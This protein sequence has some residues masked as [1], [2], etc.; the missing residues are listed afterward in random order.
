MQPSATGAEMLHPR[1]VAALIQLLFVIQGASSDATRWEEVSRMFVR[2]SESFSG[3]GMAALRAVREWIGGDGAS[4]DDRAMETAFCRLPAPRMRG[5][6]VDALREIVAP[7]VTQ[8]VRHGAASAYS[9]ATEARLDLCLEHC[10]QGMMTFAADGHCLF[11]NRSAARLLKLPVEPQAH[12]VDRRILHRSVRKL[13][14]DFAA[15]PQRKGEWLMVRSIEVGGEQVQCFPL[16]VG[17]PGLHGPEPLLHLFLIA[18]TTSEDLAE[19]L[20]RRVHLSKQETFVVRAL[21]A[22]KS[23]SAIA[24]EMR[25]S[26][27]TVRTYVE[28]VYEKLQVRNRYELL[29]LVTAAGDHPVPA[30]IPP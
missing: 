15:D 17:K 23:N 30:D 25:L 21:L 14:E 9:A 22:G 13:V 19:R 10:T 27:H 29:R 6:A 1:D 18:E 3:D 20:L 5:D 16:I 26:V 4:G 11:L 24:G 7:A 28:R 8:A 2:L 12:L